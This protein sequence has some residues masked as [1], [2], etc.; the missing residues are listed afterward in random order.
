[1]EHEFRP[2]TDAGH[3]AGNIFLPRRTCPVRAGRPLL[4]QDGVPAEAGAATLIY[5]YSPAF[6]GC[7]RTWLSSGSGLLFPRVTGRACRLPRGVHSDQREYLLRRGS[8]SPGR[9]RW[10][11]PAEG[12]VHRRQQRHWLDRGDGAE[13]LGLHV[14]VHSCRPGNLKPR[15]SWDPASAVPGIVR[16]G[17]N[18]ADPA[19]WGS[20]TRSDTVRFCSLR[21]PVP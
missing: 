7:T 21:T 11:T 16:L 13:T 15:L 19:I 17:A 12:R 1:M 14:Q 18:G 5:L 3:R 9:A 4:G 2:L 8:R 6:H 20:S 10:L